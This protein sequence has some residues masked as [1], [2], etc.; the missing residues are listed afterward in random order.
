MTKTRILAAVL[1]GLGTTLASVADGQTTRDGC[2]F[3]V[4]TSTWESSFAPGSVTTQSEEAF[5]AR[6]P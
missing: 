3:R 1:I 6:T 4:N 5:K 2:E